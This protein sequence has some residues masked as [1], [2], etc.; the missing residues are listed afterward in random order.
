MY[1]ITDACMCG[2]YAGEWCYSRIPKSRF[3]VAPSPP[4]QS[5]AV[6]LYRESV[7]FGKKTVQT[8]MRNYKILNTYM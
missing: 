1:E 3:T 8:L 7:S 5:M 6:I 4:L 2:G